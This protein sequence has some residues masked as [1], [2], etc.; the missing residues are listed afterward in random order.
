MKILIF[1]ASGFIGKAIRKN[2]SVDHEVIAAVRSQTPIADEVTVDLLDKK[3]VTNVIAGVQPD[4]II[5]SSGIVDPTADTMQNVE[6]TRNILEAVLSSGAQVS[7]IIISGS[8][9][10]YGRIEEGE[11]P[12]N[13]DTPLRA[14]AG[15]GLAKKLEEQAALE[16][17]EKGLDVVIARIFNPIGVNMAEKFFVSR[18]KKQIKEYLAGERTSLEISR[19]DSSRDYIAVEDIAAAIRVLVEGNPI[20]STYNIGSGVPMSNGE[21]LQLMLNSSKIG[22]DP[23]IV[24]TAIEPEPLIANQ[25]DIMRLQ[26]EFN[27]KPQHNIADIVE[28]IMND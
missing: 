20:H 28:E 15:Y 11:L 26:Q 23:V 25:A 18:I 24:E 1:G 2:L 8:A 16:Y 3:A 10:E 12:V 14:D 13:E 17:R 22:N 5:N 27:W 7:R 19:K 4:V 21:L 6:F 9:G